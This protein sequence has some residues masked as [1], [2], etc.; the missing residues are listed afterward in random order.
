LVDS[1]VEKA[2]L[3]YSS[4]PKE[5]QEQIMS[6]QQPSVDSESIRVELSDGTVANLKTMGMVG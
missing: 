6:L 1:A 2:S 5:Q 4:K 3:W